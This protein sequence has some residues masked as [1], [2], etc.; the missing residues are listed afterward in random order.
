MDRRR[1]QIRTSVRLG[2]GNAAVEQ[3]PKGANPLPAAPPALPKTPVHPEMRTSRRPTSAIARSYPERSGEPRPTGANPPPAAS[4]KP[5]Q[6][7][8][9]PGT[10][11]TLRPPPKFCLHPPQ[12][13]TKSAR[14]PWWAGSGPSSKATPNSRVGRSPATGP[15]VHPRFFRRVPCSVIAMPSTPAIL[16]TC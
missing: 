5:T 1:A 14:D 3:R 12:T 8:R 15:I 9:F 11:P 10:R 13:S 7:P 4:P 2:S 6:S 16:P